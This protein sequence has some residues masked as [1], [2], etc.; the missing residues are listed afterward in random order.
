MTGETG[1]AI[2]GGV[3]FRSARNVM[4]QAAVQTA[5]P[6]LERHDVW[7]DL[8]PLL[9]GLSPFTKQ[10]GEELVEQAIR[11]NRSGNSRS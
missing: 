5:V 7:R 1:N 4:D 8:L 9:F 2:P 10:F 6:V 3:N 11:G